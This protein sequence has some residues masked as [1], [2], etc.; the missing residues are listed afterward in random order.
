MLVGFCYNG[1]MKKYS[2]N[3]AITQ[4]LEEL[5]LESGV[6]HGTTA[7]S[8][9]FDC[10]RCGK[11]N[12]LYI[13][14]DSGHFQ[15]HKCAED[16]F[17]GK[18]EFA[19]AG[20]LGRNINDIRKSLYGDIV[21][22]AE[23]F[24][25]FTIENHYSDDEIVEEVPDLTAI[26]TVFWPKDA[27]EIDQPLARKGADYL[28]KRGIPIDVAVK[29][30]I[31]YSGMQTRVLFP[32]KYKEHLFGWQGRFI[33]QTEFT[34][35]V[36]GKKTTIPKALTSEGLK[37]DKS[38]MFADNIDGSGHIIVCEG[39]IDA[40]K[41]NLC[42]G[43]VATMGK[44]VS[45]VQINIIKHSGVSKVYLALDEDAADQ[46]ERLIKELSPYVDVYEVEVP[47]GKDD[48]GD[49]SFEEAQTAFLSAEKVHPGKMHIYLK[50]PDFMTRKFN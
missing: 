7:T 19:L 3:S 41:F 12:L 26:P 42:G 17:R 1:H 27:I 20:I 24:L 34:N 21:P 10:P 46:T 23:A 14:K 39:P 50:L 9:V 2:T 16:G 45:E 32:V 18:P 30:G 5:L 33:G 47:K 36:T 28:L 38:I 49:C 31:R 44:A 43:A 48:F 25:A 22:T 11:H 13:Y 15:C 29:Y 40:I 6:K 37:K 8:Y 35:S 4:R